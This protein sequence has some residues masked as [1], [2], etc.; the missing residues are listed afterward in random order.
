MLIFCWT[1]W[2]F[3]VGN[4][5]MFIQTPDWSTACQFHLFLHLKRFQYSICLVYSVCFQIRIFWLSSTWDWVCL[6]SSLNIVRSCS[7]LWSQIFPYFLF[8]IFHLRF[9]IFHIFPVLNF[10]LNSWLYCCRLLLGIACARFYAPSHTRY[11][12]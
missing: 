7:F 1:V 10:E 4:G 9:S 11:C 12:K 8:H 5:F 3:T 6:D 2:N